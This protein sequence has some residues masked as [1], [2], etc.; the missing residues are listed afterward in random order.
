MLRSGPVRQARYRPSPTCPRRRFRLWRSRPAVKP[1][2]VALV[3]ARTDRRAVAGLAGTRLNHTRQPAVLAEQ[4]APVDV[5]AVRVAVVAP[6]HP[7]PARQPLDVE[8][9]DRDVRVDIHDV[10]R[11][12]GPA[13]RY[14]RWRS[15]RLRQF[16]RHVEH[17][18]DGRVIGV[19]VD[20]EDRRLW[21][22]VRRQRPGGLSKEVAAL[23]DDEVEPPVGANWAASAQC[24]GRTPTHGVGTSWA[25]TVA[26]SRPWRSRNRC[27]RPP[28]RV[29]DAC[30]RPSRKMSA[31]TALTVAP[32]AWSSRRRHASYDRPRKRTCVIRTNDSRRN[33]A[34]A[35][36][37]RRRLI[38]G[39]P[40]I[41]QTCVGMVVDA[42]DAAIQDLS[43]SEDVTLHPLGLRVILVLVPVLCAC[44]SQ[45][46]GMRG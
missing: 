5:S 42:H 44:C 19:V 4:V 43:R 40:V 30:L 10:P 14:R 35:R 33:H 45:N 27:W 24:P 7:H 31:S 34:A 18:H 37:A 20:I 17:P 32:S 11:P 13:R 12:A 36:A 15:C 9:L 3:L 16:D 28:L 6:R 25:D 41:R 39:L 38:D 2:G 1:G 22:G 26:R 8:H 29:R 23:T 46:N 21:S